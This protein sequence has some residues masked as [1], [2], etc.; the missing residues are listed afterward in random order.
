MFQWA[1]VAC[2]YIREPKS[3]GRKKKRIEQLLNSAAEHRGQDLLNELYKGVLEEYFKDEEALFRFLV[4]QLLAAFEPLSIRSLSTLQ[5]HA[6]DDNNA[7][8]SVV[9]TL[10]FLGSLLSNVTSSDDTLPIVPLHTSFR[11]FVT[12]EE[13]SSVFYVDLRVAHR[14]LAHSCLS[15]LL[16][17]LKFNICGLESSYLANKDV[18]DLESRIVEHLPPALSYA[19]RF[20]DDHLEP[21]DF[22]TDLFGKLQ[23]F[24]ERKFLFWLEALSLMGDLGLASPALSS[25][26]V[27]LASGQGVSITVDSMKGRTTNSS[28]GSKVLK[29]S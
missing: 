3:V 18:E 1:A 22:E 23:S 28:D 27:W 19:C 17:D 21:F 5:R 12:N 6:S 9:E 24:F 7:P 2:G 8:N 10:R 4:G 16:D 20:W 25:L 11:D 14:Q 26:S 29:Q 13:K 15:L